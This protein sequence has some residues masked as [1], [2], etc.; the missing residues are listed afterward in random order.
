[1]SNAQASV[2]HCHTASQPFCLQKS[3]WS[4]FPRLLPIFHTLN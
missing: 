2:S 1:M 4:E 3:R